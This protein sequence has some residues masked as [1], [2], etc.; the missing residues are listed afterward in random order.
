MTPRVKLRSRQSHF[1]VTE[2]RSWVP[3]AGVGRRVGGRGLGAFSRRATLYVFTGVVTGA[4]ARVRIHQTA[5]LFGLT[6]G[7]HRVWGGGPT[8]S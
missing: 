8:H 6:L 2:S 1:R 3:E 7:Q 4:C 5:R